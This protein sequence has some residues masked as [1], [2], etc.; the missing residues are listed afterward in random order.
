MEEK[1]Y[2]YAELLLKKG[3]CIKEGEPLVISAPIESFPFVRVLTKVAMEVGV[4]DI[5]FD[6]YDDEIKH[7]LLKYYDEDDIKKCMFWNKSIHDKYAEKNGAFLFLVDA[8]PNSMGDIKTEKLKFAS[9][10]S[11]KTRKL[12]REKQENNQIDWCIAAVATE[13]WSKLLFPNDVLSLEKLWDVIFDIC[14]INTKDPL[15]SWEEKM[16]LNREQCCKLNDLKIK[17]LHYTNSLGT[18]LTVNLDKRAL[19]CGGSSLIGDRELIV[20]LPTEE[21]F[22]TPN[23]FKTN[24]IVYSSLPLVHS[25]V[26][27]KDICLEFCDGK[28]VKYDASVGREELGNILSVDSESSMLGE[29]ALVDKNSKIANSNMLFFETLYDENASCHIAVGMG[30]KECIDGSS[31]F[32]DEQLETIGYNKSRGHVDIMIGTDDLKITAITFEEKEIIL[33]EDGSFKI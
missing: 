11:L 7:T 15:K 32:S 14:L 20:N 9:V 16:K 12:Y 18:N 1:Y 27:I 30:F 13:A 2:K 31:D 24:G 25:G 3:L 22:T 5:Y 17:E 6:Y 21:V 4:R 29:I 26:L 28:V 10:Y 33:F 19:W 8:N 23:K